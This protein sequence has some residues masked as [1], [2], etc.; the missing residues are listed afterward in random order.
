MTHHMAFSLASGGAPARAGA[1]SAGASI[2]TKPCNGH[3]HM[4]IS[5][6]YG[7]PFPVSFFPVVKESTG[8]HAALH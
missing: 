6:I 7:D 3:K 5:A 1:V 8:G 2:E 4:A